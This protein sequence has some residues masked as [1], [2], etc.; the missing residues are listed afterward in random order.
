V[1][2]GDIDGDGDLDLAAGNGSTYYGGQPNKVYI[3]ADGALQLTA[4]FT[5]NDSDATSSV[6][7][8]DMDGDGDLDLA[9]GNALGPNKVYLN[10]GGVLQPTAIFASNDSDDTQSVAWGDIYRARAQT[11]VLA[12]GSRIIWYDF[13]YDHPS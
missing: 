13:T 5:S 1:A 6:A 11:A 12:R 3:N 8:G 4:I 2:W 10:V 7:W 9:A